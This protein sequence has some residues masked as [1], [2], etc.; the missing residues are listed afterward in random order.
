MA[1]SVMKGPFLT[2]NVAKDPFLTPNVAKGPFL[3]PNVAKG[4]FL[5][6]GGRAASCS[7]RPG[8]GS[9]RRVR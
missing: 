8:C 9:G 7:V 2:P 1:P 4:P 6:L 3:T 5:T